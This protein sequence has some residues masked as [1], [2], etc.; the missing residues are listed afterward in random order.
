M[1]KEIE[2]T[3]HIH[4][5][6][7]ND[8]NMPEG[9]TEGELGTSAPDKKFDQNAKELVFMDPDSGEV[10]HY[11]MNGKMVR[12]IAAKLKQSNKSL[13]AQLKKEAADLRARALL[14]GGP[15]PNGSGGGGA[16]LSPE[17]VRKISE[18]G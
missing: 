10:I 5:F 12:T 7:L 4:V 14:A 16:L 17:Q 13:D 1:S 6:P 8:G 2:L 9:Y 3:A 18:G 15:G 11:K